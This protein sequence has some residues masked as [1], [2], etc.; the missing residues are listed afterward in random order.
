MCLHRTILQPHPQLLVVFLL[1]VIDDL[2]LM[3]QSVGLFDARHEVG[4]NHRIRRAVE[5]VAIWEILTNA[6]NV[7]FNAAWVFIYLGQEIISRYKIAV[8]HRIKYT[9]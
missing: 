3:L 7:L 2:T 1:H 9:D 5:E 6:T 8:F 4:L